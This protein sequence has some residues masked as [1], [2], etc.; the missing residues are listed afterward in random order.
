MATNYRVIARLYLKSE[1]CKF[2]KNSLYYLELAISTKGI[3]IDQEKVNMVSNWSQDQMTANSCF[4]NLFEVQQFL[5]CCKY[6]QRF[7]NGYLNVAEPLTMMTMNDQHVQQ[8]EDQQLAFE[9]IINRLLT[10]PIF[11][12]FHHEREVLTETI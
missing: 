6:Y 5:G 3:S 8:L 11:T 10:A 1:K 7:I 9:E 2:H 12:N 4:N